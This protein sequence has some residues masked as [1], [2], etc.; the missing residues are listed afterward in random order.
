MN[1][2]FRM[3]SLTSEALSL[4]LEDVLERDAKYEKTFQQDFTEEIRYL[5][6]K[7]SARLSKR[8]QLAE[9]EAPPNT[10]D[11]VEIH[12]SEQKKIVKEI[13]R[14]LAK[15]THPDIAGD[16]AEEEFKLIQ[17]AYTTGDLVSLMAAANRNGVAPDLDDEDLA[18]LQSALE[19]QKKEIDA[20]KQTVRWRWGVSDKNAEL[21]E[22]ITYTLGIHPSEYKAWKWAEFQAVQAKAKKE[23]LR[24]E[25]VEKAKREERKRQARKRAA[26]AG[27]RN[28]TRAKDLERARKKRE[29]K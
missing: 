2:R 23:R 27:G 10:N 16:E 12:K 14:S 5:M 19:A 15:H 6:E 8:A 28:P 18:D 4:E 3:I 17:T 11:N 25:K 22:S 26:R 21:R 9:G 24:R 13:Y 20:I 29:Q 1:R 7:E